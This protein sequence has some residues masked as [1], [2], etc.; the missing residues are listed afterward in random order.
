MAER[1]LA[2]CQAR[3]LSCFTIGRGGQDLRLV[4][5]EA[6]AH[7]S[8]ISVDHAGR[9]YDL[10]L[11][12]PG[13]FMVSNALVAAGLAI[14][15]G[16]APDQVMAALEQLTGAPGRLEQ[17]GMVRGAPVLIDYAHKPDALEHVLSALRPLALRHLVVVFGC[18]G[19]RDPGKRP[20]MGAIAARLADVVIVTDDNPRSEDPAL[21]RASILADCPGGRAIADRGE[22]IA[23]AMAGLD[24]GDLLVIAGKGHETGQIVGETILSFS[25]RDVVQR[26]MGTLS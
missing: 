24:T 3:G 14:T 11:P 26:L 21:I 22:A 1:V 18:G 8:R 5:C 10:V 6:G 25:D 16:A 9:R 17:V 4:D 12:V 2:A 15:T 13:D 23:V 19:D 20:I 7:A